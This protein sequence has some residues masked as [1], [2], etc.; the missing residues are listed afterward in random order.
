MKLIQ[1]GENFIFL[2]QFC[3]KEIPK[4]AG[5]IWKPSIGWHTSNAANACKLIKYASPE[6]LESISEL[7]AQRE[8]SLEASRKASSDF[9]PPAPA[10]LSYLPYQRAGIEFAL[11]RKNT[12]LA[13]EMGLGKTIQ[14]IGLINACE[15]IKRALIVCPASLKI[16]WR[17]EL[18]KWLV[19]PLSI[20]IL[21]DA[22]HSNKNANILIVNY[23]ILDK[24]FEDIQYDF[25]DLLILDESHYIKSSAQI[26]IPLTEEERKH[27]R[28]RVRYI[29]KVNR[30]RAVFQVAPLCDRKVFLTGTPITN[31][32]KEAFT[33]IQLLCPDEFPKSFYSYAKRYCSGGNDGYGF[34]ANGDSHLDELQ[35]KLR[36][37]VMI[38]RLKMDVLTELPPKRRQIME[39]PS[40]GHAKEIQAE[41]NAFFEF[42]S[43][44]EAL[45]LEME[46]AQADENAE[47]YA[48]KVNEMRV[49]N[50]AGFE[51][52]SKLRH[53]TAMAKLPM[54]K[55]F[56]NDFISSGEK[57]VVF[58]HHHDVTD[59]LLKM[60]NAKGEIAVALDG[61]MAMERRQRS[62]ELFQNDP[63]VKVF[64]GSIAAAGVG[65]T[66][67]A[68]STVIFGEL[69]WVPGNMSQAEDRLHRIGQVYPVNVIHLVLENSLDCKMA[70]TLIDKQDVI[71]RALDKNVK[72]EDD[73]D[74]EA[75]E[76]GLSITQEVTPE[77][78]PKVKKPAPLAPVIPEH[79]REAIHL[80]LKVL[81]RMCDH[82]S[83][84][85]DAGFNGFDAKIG[86]DLA[87]RASLSEKQAA[88]AKKLLKKYHRQ[89]PPDLYEMIFRK[90]AA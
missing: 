15:D 47:L 77:V 17:K 53:Q 71:D 82:A 79:E 54:A 68:A 51:E 86:H 61:R 33:S 20:S 69:D 19:R 66:L 90:E 67:T 35:D 34:D 65:I 32:P 58:A 30:V 46:L 45:R 89:I 14:A 83:R 6:L 28:N 81:A 44:K 42:E 59:E 75:M 87:A 60:L 85:D 76:E 22:K 41:N 36:S 5:F 2:C 8:A 11:K 38:R 31:R 84:K 37:T 73:F 62:V 70:K 3:E 49:C 78:T 55:D 27:T 72:P 4:K 18:E 7:V 1:A 40:N 63:K 10:G 29:Y 56:I 80:S 24:W 13:D 21:S 52:L 48:H 64:I 9:N 57:V 23:D 26:T 25:F 50:M 39:L 12:W 74:L 88:V 43:R 16:N